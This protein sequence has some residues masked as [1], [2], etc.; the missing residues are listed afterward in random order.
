M[1]VIGAGGFAIELLE[2]LISK[3]YGYTKENL[4]FYDDITTDSPE[5]LFKQFLVLKS[6]EEVKAIFNNSSK[7]YCLGIGSP[8]SRKLLVD[9]FNALNGKLFSVISSQSSIGSFETLIAE[10][11]SIM[12]GVRITNGVSIGKGTLLNLNSTIGHNTKV[13][14][15][16]NLNPGVHISGGCNIGNNTSIGTGAVI[17]P[18][19][20]IGKN[21]VIGAGSVV[22]KDVP[23]DCTVVGVP[24]EIIKSF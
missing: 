1:I 18:N 24:G 6:I 19:L 5:K 17:L 23:D 8:N 2:V 15:F 9:K 11:C 12:D 21:V 3:E 14:D 10:G 13:G 16:T 22:I 4:Y 7:D 20:K